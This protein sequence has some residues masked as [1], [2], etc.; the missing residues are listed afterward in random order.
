M[1][2]LVALDELGELGG[3]LGAVLALF[4][5]TPQH[6]LLE[7]H[8]ERLLAGGGLEE[9]GGGELEGLGEWPRSF[10]YLERGAGKR[11]SLMR[12]DVQR[13]VDTMAAIAET[14]TAERFA[15]PLQDADG[16]YRL[17]YDNP[18]TGEWELECIGRFGPQGRLQ[19]KISHFS[20]YAI[21]R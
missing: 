19:F 9:G 7:L 4:G 1:L 13:D 18:E 11:R 20:K 21:G 15:A 5:Q 8:G 10:G 6:K 3:L 17:W 12:Y 14:F 2:L 16:E